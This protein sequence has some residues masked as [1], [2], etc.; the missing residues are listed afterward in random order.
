MRAQP[1]AW[2][3]SGCMRAQ[4]ASWEHSGCMEVLRLRGSIQ[5]L[6]SIQDEWE[7]SGCMEALSLYG[8]TEAVWDHLGCVGAFRLQT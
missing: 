4:P 7:H 6:W 8:S 5:A 1:A 2:K 3:H